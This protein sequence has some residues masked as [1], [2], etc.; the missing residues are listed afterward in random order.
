MHDYAARDF[1]DS[2]VLEDL[3][4]RF[5][6]RFVSTDRL[7]IDLTRFGPVYNYREPTGWRL[8]AAQLARGLMHMT[9]KRRFELN[10]RH[11]L[12]R[13]IFGV[14]PKVAWMTDFVSRAGLAR[15]MTLLLRAAL[16]LSAPSV[17]PAAK[18]PDA[19]LI[20]TPVA[21]YFADDLIRE[22]RRLGIP[23]LAVVNNWDNLNTKSFL[24]VPSYLGVWGEQGFLIARLMH[25]IPAHRIFV[26]G[27]PRFE[28]YR[29]SVLNRAEARTRLGLPADRRILL[30]CGAGIAFEET[31]LLEELDAAIDE[32]RLP[33]DLFVVYKPHPLRFAR[34]AERPFDAAAA[35]NVVLAP[36]GGRNLTEL[37]IYPDLLA[38]A[39]ALISP[40][41]TM[42]M[43][44]AQH[45]LPALCLAYSDPGHAN[46]DWNR[47]SFNLHLY[48]I[49]HSDWAI[50]C[51]SRTAFLD[52]CRELVAAIGDERIAQYAK[53]SAEMMSRTGSSSVADRIEGAV[54]SVLSQRGSDESFRLSQMEQPGTLGNMA[55]VKDA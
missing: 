7:T 35:R 20:Y 55:S 11:T 48:L 8:R 24:E 4:K 34:A 19:M 46:H 3:A 22:T 53:G 5:D 43:E 51:D 10:R 1:V 26:I 18:A 2:G 14:G 31:S 12:A 33:R 50:V 23:S 44:G 9:D 28:I 29:R 27:A 37:D 47:V 49:R 21:S 30:F 54:F 16:R 32:G 13:A 15:P 41:S 42:V 45:G 17:L 40:F 36:T 25:L 52:R 39:D 38:A 6:L